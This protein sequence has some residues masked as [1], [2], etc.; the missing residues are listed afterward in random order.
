V[1]RPHRLIA[2]GLLQEECDEVSGAFAA[3][4]LIE[5]ERRSLGEWAAVLLVSEERL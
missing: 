2:S 4:G 3:S 1:P 5:T